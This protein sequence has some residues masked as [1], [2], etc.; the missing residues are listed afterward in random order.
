VTT[1]AED[2]PLCKVKPDLEISATSGR[3]WAVC[4]RCNE[5]EGGGS[6][7]GAIKKWNRW[8]RRILRRRYV[9]N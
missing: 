8:V 7:E 4:V 9:R 2:C 1:K 3:W 6:R 5:L